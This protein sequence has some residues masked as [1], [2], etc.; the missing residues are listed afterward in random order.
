MRFL[1]GTAAVSID[2]DIQGRKSATGGLGRQNS[3]RLRCK[4]EDLLKKLSIELITYFE[5][6]RKTAAELL[7][8]AAFF[9]SLHD[10]CVTSAEEKLPVLKINH[11]KEGKR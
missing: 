8:S 6:G 11:H 2:V 1:D 9:V 4:S 10:E 3:Q 7:S 5:T